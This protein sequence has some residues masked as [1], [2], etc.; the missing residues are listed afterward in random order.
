[1]VMR[2][3]VNG[4]AWSKVF[5]TALSGGLAIVIANVILLVFLSAQFPIVLAD[6]DN[7]QSYLEGAF[8]SF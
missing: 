4:Y 8:G 7:M 1:M 5:S 2:S 6:A 3:S